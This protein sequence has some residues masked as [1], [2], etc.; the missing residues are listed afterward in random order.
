MRPVL[1]DNRL[2]WRG[3]LRLHPLGQV[4]GDARDLTVPNGCLAAKCVGNAMIGVPMP[5][6]HTVAIADK[7]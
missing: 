3:G 7:A 4:A 1:S 5:P 6:R 2:C